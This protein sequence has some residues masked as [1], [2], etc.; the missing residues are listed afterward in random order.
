MTDSMAGDMQLPI[1]SPPA[2]TERQ[3]PAREAGPGGCPVS[4]ECEGVVRAGRLMCREHW[5]MV[6][7]RLRNEVWTAWE[8]RSRAFDAP[9]NE[10]V[11]WAAVD[12][13]ERVKLEA[14]ASARKHEAAKA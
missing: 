9:L 14:I 3:P 2:T 5:R 1:E 12:L 13:H 6:P 7:A 10:D 8:A 4:V 11:Y